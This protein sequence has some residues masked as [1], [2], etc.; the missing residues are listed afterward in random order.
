[1]HEAR[2]SKPVLW[3]NLKG[4]LEREEGVGFRM[5]GTHVY[6]R[7]VRVDEWQKPSQYCKGI[8]LQL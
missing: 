3:D 4:W 1:M 7:P 2:Q 5:E 6:L 8:S